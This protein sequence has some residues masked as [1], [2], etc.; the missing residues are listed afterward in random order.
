[1]NRKSKSVARQ[2]SS[3]IATGDFGGVYQARVGAY[4]STLMLARH[5]P[6]FIPGGALT[7]I[8][9]QREAFGASLDDLTTGVAIG[10]ERI[11]LQVSIKS[12]VE[13]RPT[14]DGFSTAVKKAQARAAQAGGDA[15]VFHL[16]VPTSTK[17]LAEVNRLQ[18]FSD[19]ESGEEFARIIS[20]SGAEIQKMAAQFQ[21]LL[22]TARAPLG[23]PGVWRF[24]KQ[25]KVVAL[26]LDT[27]EASTAKAAAEAMLA[28]HFET[29]RACEIFTLIERVVADK[30]PRARRLTPESLLANLRSIIP[31]LDDPLATRETARRIW[32]ASEVVVSEIQRDVGTLHLD[33]SGVVASC[34]AALANADVDVVVIHGRPGSGKSAIL[35]DLYA[36]A[37]GSGPILF[38][39]SR[40]VANCEGWVEFASRRLGSTQDIGATVTVL[41]GNAR[42]P[43]VFVDGISEIVQPGA[44]AVVNEILGA[45][46]QGDEFTPAPLLV[47]SS[48]DSRLPS[49]IGKEKGCTARVGLGDLSDD[50]IGSVVVA[51]PDLAPMLTRDRAS[52]VSRTLYA[53]QL[54]VEHKLGR[55]LEFEGPITE[56]DFI[57]AWWSGLVGRGELGP[58]RKQA[59]L[60]IGAEHRSDPS[61]TFL[62]TDVDPNALQS[63][64]DDRLVYE[65]PVRSVYGFT[66]D[67]LSD[68][69]V[70]RTL[71]RDARDLA[72]IV[73]ELD[74][75]PY[76]TQPVCLVAQS[77]LEN[78]ARQNEFETLYGQFGLDEKAE[79]FRSAMV[80]GFIRSPK[81]Y[82]ILPQM[83]TA[84][85]ARNQGLLRSVLLGL[86][87]DEVDPHP[88]AAGWSRDGDDGGPL[89]SAG[90]LLPVPRPSTWIPVL[91]YMLKS[92]ERFDR[93]SRDVA[94]AAFNIWQ[95]FSPTG[96]PYRAEIAAVAFR[97]MDAIQ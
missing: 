31:D 28:A 33:R 52:Y 43:T 20:T 84:L 61:R 75:P 47:A 18:Y 23:L 7:W 51:Y 92:Y 78:E 72:K 74:Y 5:Q 40:K 76:L 56:V 42:R 46:R 37:K 8:A 39:S 44:Q 35:R 87:A 66:H 24:L 38:L 86:I 81:S 73:H 96:S 6:P 48:R 83:E 13:F 36:Q 30:N 41:R 54:V 55:D 64:I 59:L 26:D 49:W 17:H 2:V 91:S 14:D 88:L 45:L 94:L 67:L 22:G 65:D 80:L 82:F 32:Q 62:A 95:R 9:F 50:E 15:C 1:V 11:E 77:I 57:S 29:D 89:A 60:K 97:E 58:R 71:D 16:V 68:W 27:P 63:L 79:A 12:H 69:T 25:F 53:I 19:Q 21:A 3:P 4:Y 90:Y 34:A 85:F 93:L 10:D 70:F